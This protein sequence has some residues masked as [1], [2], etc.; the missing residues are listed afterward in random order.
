MVIH[1]EAYDTVTIQE[2]SKA[3]LMFR[4]I[5]AKTHYLLESEKLYQESTT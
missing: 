1:G 3:N 4:A 2:T 5:V